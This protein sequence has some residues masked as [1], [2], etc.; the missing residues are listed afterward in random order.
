M[1][2]EVI[3]QDLKAVLRRLKLSRMLDTLPERLAVARTQQ[4]PH[5]DLLL[6]V[7]SDEASRR[8]PEPR[9]QGATGERSRRRRV[10]RR[11]PLVELREKTLRI[12]PPSDQELER[13][14]ELLLEGHGFTAKRSMNASTR[15][16]VTAGTPSDSALTTR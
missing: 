2:P 6:L 1:N 9:D 3:T 7:L 8:E 13:S 14:A 15:S 12:T 5:Q 16:T 11:R 10:V 4:K